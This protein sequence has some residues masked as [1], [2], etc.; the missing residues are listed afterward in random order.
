LRAAKGDA[1]EGE[2]GTDTI[3]GNTEEENDIVF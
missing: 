3:F 2:E 1:A